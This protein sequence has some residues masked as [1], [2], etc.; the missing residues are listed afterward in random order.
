[1]RQQDNWAQQALEVKNKRTLPRLTV[2]GGDSKQ[3]PLAGRENG[4]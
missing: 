3:H 2:R 4:L 1:M